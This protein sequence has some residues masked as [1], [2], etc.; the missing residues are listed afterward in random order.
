MDLLPAGQQI[1]I[2]HAAHLSSIYT[3]FLWKC[4]LECSFRLFFLEASA[5]PYEGYS[6]TIQAISGP[7]A[8]G[9]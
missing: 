4:F 9:V 8:I 1:S 6:Y 3:G 7:S 5:A 2:G